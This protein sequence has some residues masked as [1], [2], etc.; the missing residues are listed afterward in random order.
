ML[1][2]G[3]ESKEELRALHS[4]RHIRD[5]LARPARRSYLSDFIYGGIDGAVTTFAVVSS[6]AGANLDASIV[7]ILGVANLVADGFSMAAANFL[8]ARAEA[9]QAQWARRSEEIEIDRY[10]EGER[11]EIRQIF[12]AK[13]FEGD[14]LERVVE[15]ITGDRERWIETMLAEEHGIG[16]A[17]RNALPAA[18]AT[19]A[20][21]NLIGAIP[22]VPFVLALAAAT[23]MPRPFAASAGM[24]AVAFFAVG[25]LKSRFVEQRWWI[26]GL[27]TLAIGALAA[28][29]AYGIGAALGG[30][31]L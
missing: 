12:R 28:G 20:A 25:A 22:L 26:A 31:A 29:L 17:R 7:M 2:K 30:L 24:T 6:A 16:T 8:G 13:G 14:T 27:E 5:R 15:V 11:E 9:Q 3:N 1:I 10:P 21:F 4:P 18:A 19:F 23:S